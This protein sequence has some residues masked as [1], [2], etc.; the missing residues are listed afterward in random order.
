MRHNALAA[1]VLSQPIANLGLVPG[2]HIFQAYVPYQP[3]IQKD[4]KRR[5][6]PGP[7]FGLHGPNKI[8]RVGLL[9]VRGHPRQ[10]FIQMGTVSIH[11]GK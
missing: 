3:T 5:R 1:G 9:D 10:K 2:Y 4:A 11:Y 7:A 6:P 8:E